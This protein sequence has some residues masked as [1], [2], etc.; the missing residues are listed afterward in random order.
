M[1]L[2]NNMIINGNY[3][4]KYRG[5]IPLILLILSIPIIWQN[6]DHYIYDSNFKL[7]CSISGSLLS[8]LGLLLRYYTIGST[9]E[10][11]S[12]RNRN[13]Q[14]AKYLNTRGAYSVIRHP[15]YLAN[16]FIWLG[17][18]IFSLSYMLIIITTLLFIIHYE[19]IVLVEEQ[20]LVKKFKKK[21][22]K[23]CEITPLLF[24]NFK[25]F[26][27]PGN[28]FSIKKIIKQ[29][30]SSTFS[31]IISFLYIDFLINITYAM[32]NVGSVHMYNNIYLYVF[33]LGIIGYV[34][35][36]L[37]VFRKH[38]SLLDD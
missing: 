11:T 32:Q 30:Y 31:T 17:L 12:G 24:P 19:R 20:F 18:A 35:M 10:G 2:K 38:T 5:Q 9:P 37:K 16:Y 6:T 8:L 28:I 21:Y 36:C 26:K 13:Q 15:L 25:N 23:F 29:E 3:L 34:T 27:K 14:V 4:F 7:I 22:E 33:L 1:Q